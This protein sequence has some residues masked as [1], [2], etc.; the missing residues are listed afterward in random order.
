MQPLFNKTLNALGGKTPLSG[1]WQRMQIMN[2]DVPGEPAAVF[3]TRYQLFEELGSGGTGCVYRAL[4]RLTGDWLAYKRLF[5]PTQGLLLAASISS[6]N[7]PSLN[8]AHEFR[9]LAG[10]RHPHIISVFDFGFDPQGDPF[11]TM[12]LLDQPQ[13]LV[14]AG[15]DKPLDV[16]VA[17]LGQMLQALAYLHQY[18][19]VHCDL[20]PS[21]VLVNAGHVKLVDFGLALAGEARDEAWGTLPYMAPEVLAGRPPSV[22]ADLYAAGVMAYEMLAGRPPFEGDDYDSLAA[23]ITSASPDLAQTG[24][25]ANLRRVLACL[26][27]KRPAERPAD[28][29]QALA[30]LGA[31]SGAAMVV[32]TREMRESFLQ[33]ASFVGHEHELRVL[34]D[35][36]DAAGAAHGGAWLVAGESGVG[37]SRL[38]D[39][40]RVQALV[41]GALVL[42]GQAVSEG[43]QRYQLWRESVA[44]MALLVELNDLE[45]GVLQTIVPDLAARL[46]RAVPE[47]P[48]LDPKVART[49]LMAVVADLVQRCACQ[50][51]LVFVLED[52][53]W[54]GANSLALLSW[55]TR[56]IAD[57]PVL[58]LASYRQDEAPHLA[59][60]LPEMRV[61]PLPRLAGTAIAALSAAMLG[62]GGH[63]PELVHFLEQETEGN[64]FFLVEVVRALAEEGGGLDQV[65]DMALPAHVLTGGVQQIVQRRLRRVPA[66]GQALLRLAAVAGRQLDLAVL[67]ALAPGTQLGPWL[68][69]CVDAA[70]LEAQGAQ[71]RFAHDKLRDGVLAELAPTERPELHARV[72]RAL[73]A[74]YPGDAQ[75]AGALAYH[76]GQA[77]DAQ[78]EAHYAGIAG[79]QAAERF[80][81]AEALAYFSRALE[82]TPAGESVRR[83]ALLLGREQVYQLL[84]ERT[85]QEQDLSAL[86]AL[87]ETLGDERRLAEIHNHRAQRY[88]MA[89]NYPAAVAAAQAGLAA[90]RR[91]GDQAAEAGSLVNW[92]VA[93]YRRGDYIAARERLR[94][95]LA[96]AA[97]HPETQALALNHLGTTHLEV[98]EPSPA[99]E[100]YERALAIWSALGNRRRQAA[101]LNNLGVLQ[102]ESG[103]YSKTIDYLEQTLAIQITLGDR[104]GEAY[105][106]LNLGSINIMLGNY[107]AAQEY[108]EQ[109]LVIHRAIGERRAEAMI[110][111]NLA[112]LHCDLHEYTHAR[113][114]SRQALEI[115]EAIELGREKGYVLAYLGMALEGLEDFA[116]ARSAFTQA[117]AIRRELGQQGL[118]SDSL[119]D[120]ARVALAQGEQAEALTYVRE[121]LAHLQAHGTAGLDHPFVVYESCVRVLA[122]CGEAEQAREVR[123]AAC[124]LLHAHAAKISDAALR[125]CFLENVPAH[126]ALLSD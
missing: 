12:E 79:Q 77:E 28:A 69:G 103:D 119:A 6:Q 95:A 101:L 111:T 126:R 65:G 83:Y 122:A 47:P 81:N 22:A 99:Q 19:V 17:L 121:V 49:R 114:Y 32:E 59:A 31:A 48:E 117:L 44:W 64:A 5:V 68:L 74:V 56:L 112:F 109:A 45:A 90:A 97:D 91:S 63:K 80:A 85:A 62:V 84:G 46:G 26:L 58:M 73:E 23:Q 104:P 51:P 18:G 41:A 118:V 67:A 7:D 21:N 96:L 24:A 102:V 3:R 107:H 39:E 27:A 55:L 70:V 120:L 115:A 2:S 53:H 86:L 100:Y 124:A 36:L 125:R 94:Q 8:L 34:L 87:A 92:G 89:G 123:A 20:K 75:Q 93:L 33:A 106:R 61:L 9:V 10:L 16:Q 57:Q 4:D 78:R 29:R 43:G 82:L 71:W 98:G 11:F 113:V 52:L 110:L 38:L 42:R 66:A 105:T 37:K 72:A 40:L 50:Q 88:E 13:T 25:P 30:A 35:A 116:A 108:L 1:D 60:E 15:H 14:E 76:W 54:A